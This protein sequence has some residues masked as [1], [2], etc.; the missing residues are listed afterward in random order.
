LPAWTFGENHAEGKPPCNRHHVGVTGVIHHWSLKFMRRISPIQ[1]EELLKIGCAPAWL[2]SLDLNRASD[3]KS[4][5]AVQQ[6]H[7]DATGSIY[8]RYFYDT[9]HQPSKINF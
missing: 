1:R 9:R 8:R 6:R 5:W 2:D 3:R 4:L 7:A